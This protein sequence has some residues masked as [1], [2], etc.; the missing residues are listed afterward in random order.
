VARSRRK[1]VGRS[2]TS[3]WWGLGLSM[4]GAAQAGSITTS[5]FY[6]DL[7]RVIEA[8]TISNGVFKRYD[9]YY[10][11]P[12]GNPLQIIHYSS[13]SLSTEE[14][15]EV[16]LNL[17]GGSASL[18]FTAAQDD[19]VVLNVGSVAMIPVGSSVTISI[20]DSGG[21]LID[22]AATTLG[23]TITLPNL[24]GDTYSVVISP[25]PGAT[26]AMQVSLI[27]TPAPP[28]PGQGESRIR[29]PSAASPA[30]VRLPIIS[31]AKRPS[32]PP[33]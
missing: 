22:S 30:S 4:A 11:D 5:Y 21:T 12:N 24:T 7:K 9:T 14:P 26:G 16:T 20:Y 17:P 29:K 19:T 6:D 32:R 18:S 8:D 25:P 3:F 23:A 1:L 15:L 33:Q 2:H 28:D 13:G 27:D 31:R 10:Y